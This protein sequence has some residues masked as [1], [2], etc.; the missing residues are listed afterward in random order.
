MTTRLSVFTDGLQLSQAVWKGWLGS[1]KSSWELFPGSTT[2]SQNSLHW[3]WRFK[4]ETGTNPGEL[5]VRMFLRSPGELAPSSSHCTTSS[6]YVCTLTRGF[7]KCLSRAKCEFQNI[8][9]LLVQDLVF[10]SPLK[11]RFINAFQTVDLSWWEN[12]FS[13]L[14]HCF[15][16]Q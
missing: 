10:R 16:F 9:Q 12:S 14:W 2:Q 6:F 5:K 7:G 3:S 4:Q 1:W 11:Y 8:F 13:R 15:F